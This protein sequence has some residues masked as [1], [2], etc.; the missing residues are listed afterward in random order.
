S[1]VGAVEDARLPDHVRR[2]AFMTYPE[3]IGAA[4]R[5]PG[6]AGPNMVVQRRYPLR[7]AYRDGKLFRLHAPRFASTWIDTLTADDE[8]NDTPIFFMSGFDEITRLD[9]VAKAYVLQAQGQLMIH[10]DAAAARSL[11]RAFAIAP[12]NPEVR[13]YMAGLALE[14]GHAAESRQL[15]AGIRLEQLPSELRMLLTEI[16]RALDPPDTTQMSR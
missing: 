2:V 9:D 16:H 5:T 14:A 1:L 8:R 4:A 11:Q 12:T 10:N 3:Q 7:D 15:V 6:K 13:V